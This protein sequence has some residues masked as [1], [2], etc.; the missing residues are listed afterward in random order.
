MI[1]LKN[2]RV[3]D[4]TQVMAGP[5]C[6]MLLADMGADVIKVEPPGKGEN[7]RQM[8][9]PFVNGESGA[10]LSVNRNK[11][12]MTINL[13]TE[14][15]KKLFHK[16]ATTADVVVEN[17]RPGVVR[18]LGIDYETLS[19][20]NPR[21]VYCSISGFGQ[22]GPY[23]N[24][25]GYDLIAQGMT[26]IMSV[27][28]ERGGNPVKCGLP[29]TDLGAGMFACYGILTALLAR[30]HTGKGQYVDTSLFEA[31]IAMS[32][33]E[34][35][36]YWYSGQIPQPTGSGHRISTP[37]QAFKASDGYFTVG[38][39]APHHWPKFCEIIRLPNLPYD[40]RFID[41]TVRLK[42]LSELILLVEEQTKNQT[43][44]YW[45]EKFEDA[46]IPAGPIQTYAESLCDEHTLSRKM[47]TNLEHPIA[48]SIKAL[49]I[50]VKLSETPGEIKSP[51]PLLG[52]HTEEI[53]QEIG[54]ENEE[55]KRMRQNGIA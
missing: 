40:E 25:G 1:A 43:R 22:T 6:S 54:F 18:R 38:A 37:Y 14:E 23:S 41:G 5:Y 49:G 32:V 7:T 2:I 4:L 28:G 30:E 3:I 26:G 11:R 8:G 15:G 21:I 47:V 55:I 12:G 46:G 31:G 29:I 19:G 35:T 52:E 10:F 36:E 13:K 27:T 16:L 34:S 48:G 39:D 24:R 51:A 45:M 20:I 50:P 44:S 53:L 17:Y 33:W 9:P 42:N